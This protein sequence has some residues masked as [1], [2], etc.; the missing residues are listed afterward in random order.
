MILKCPETKKCIFFCPLAG[1][2]T[3]GMASILKR[4]SLMRRALANTQVINLC[5]VG[6]RSDDCSGHNIWLT[7]LYFHSHQSVH[8]P[9]LTDLQVSLSLCH[10]IGPNHTS[11]QDNHHQVVAKCVQCLLFNVIDENNC[12]LPP[13]HC[14]WG[15]WE[16]TEAVKLHQSPFE[17]QV[18]YGRILVQKFQKLINNVI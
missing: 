12:L 13:K 15:R 4:Y 9:H 16:Q 10:S 2:P 7:F 6:L 17:F 14:W 3:W 1:N 8:W 18:Q 5:S 11:E